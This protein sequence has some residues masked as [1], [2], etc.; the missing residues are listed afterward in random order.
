LSGIEDE[1]QR[2]G[3]AEE[4]RYHGALDRRGKVEFLRRL[5]V[6]SMPATYAEPKGLSVLEAMAA[7]VPVVEPR[8]GSFPEIVG[9]AG[10]GLLCEP[11]DAASLAEAISSLYRNP[12]QAADLGRAGARGV[13]EHYTAARM[14]ARALEV[15]ATLI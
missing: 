4:F 7:G 8:H 3:L 5:S 12:E 10:G 11:N 9:R 14:G 15:Y 2:W 13:R 6:F 1:M